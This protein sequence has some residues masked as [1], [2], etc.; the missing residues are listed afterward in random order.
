MAE[1]IERASEI[2]AGT[3]RDPKGR[4]GR[5]TRPR[6]RS[7]ELTLTAPSMLAT[8]EI[9]LHPVASPR[10][11]ELAARLRRTSAQPRRVMTLGSP[12]NPIQ[13][14]VTGAS[15]TVVVKMLFSTAWLA[16]R[17]PD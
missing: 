5:P 17:P 15:S 13:V 8:L 9:A 4:P 16:A 3:R 10:A 6:V 7:L 11:G 14:S 12:V 1:R 2:G